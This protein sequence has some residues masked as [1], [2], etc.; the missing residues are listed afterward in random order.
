MY[1]SETRERL[2]E[3]RKSL[4]DL[5]REERGLAAAVAAEE[6][7]A[8]VAGAYD[9]DLLSAA[10]LRLCR[11]AWTRR[12][13]YPNTYSPDWIGRTAEAEGWPR[14][15]LKDALDAGQTMG[16]LRVGT[17]IDS[18]GRER[19][20]VRATKLAVRSQLFAEDEPEPDLANLAD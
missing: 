10:V 12:D 11:E 19:P 3:V 6:R 16:F 5:R 13:C 1:I 17:R 7:H 9:P 4:A 20:T 15:V 2:N 18:C 14:A 8:R